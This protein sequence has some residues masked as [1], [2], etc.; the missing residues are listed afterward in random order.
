MS[1][2]EQDYLLD[3]VFSLLYDAQDNNVTY[4][5]LEVLLRDFTKEEQENIIYNLN[6][7]ITRYGE[8][9]EAQGS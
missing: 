3:E 2:I 4:T 7:L 1:L 5:A 9:N 6:E 8:A